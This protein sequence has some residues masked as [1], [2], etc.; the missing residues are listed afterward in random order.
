M[1]FGTIAKEE[2]DDRLNQLRNAGLIKEDV[3][4]I[5]YIKRTF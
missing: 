2:L 3:D 1:I 4:N 5:K